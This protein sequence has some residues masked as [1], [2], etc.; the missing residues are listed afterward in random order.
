MDSST[1]TSLPG[2]GVR[3]PMRNDRLYSL[4]TSARR[5]TSPVLETA[6]MTR[7]PSRVR[8]ANFFRHRG[9]RAVKARRRLRLQDEMLAVVGVFDAKLLDCDSRQL[10]AGARC[11]CSGVR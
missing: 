7:L 11:H 9:D 2:L 10:F 6:K 3:L 4:K 8:L 1:K 5:S